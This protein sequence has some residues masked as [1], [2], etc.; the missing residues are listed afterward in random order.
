MAFY[1]CPTPTCR[2]GFDY[3]GRIA[4]KIAPPFLICEDCKTPVIIPQHTE[5]DFK[6]NIQ[7]TGYL[8]Y[9][10]YP[11]AV[12]GSMLVCLSA[13]IVASE[14]ATKS[15]LAIFPIL[16]GLA[17]ALYIYFIKFPK[18]VRKSRERITDKTYIEQLKRAGVLR[19]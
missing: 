18:D 17:P 9:L 7:K 11:S 15:Y 4:P 13:F 10:L 19:R 3:T 2:S 12:F 14:V 5:W 6:S 1:K 16:G 8:L